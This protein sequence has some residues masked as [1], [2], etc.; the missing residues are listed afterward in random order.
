MQYSHVSTHLH[1]H[2]QQQPVSYTTTEAA[3]G[4]YRTIRPSA[5]PAI[6]PSTQQQP[7][8]KIAHI[9]KRKTFEVNWETIKTIKDEEYFQN[10]SHLE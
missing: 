5:P 7:T 10:I 8:Q 6:R 1:H 2:D 3:I 4:C 9:L